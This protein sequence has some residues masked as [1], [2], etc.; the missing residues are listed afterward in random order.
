MICK[1]R[2]ADGSLQDLLK[3]LAQ[4]EENL[5]TARG[6][7]DGSGGDGDSKGV[8]DACQTFEM[9]EAAQRSGGFL[10]AVARSHTGSNV[11]NYLFPMLF[12]RYITRKFRSNYDTLYKEAMEQH[13]ES[14]GADEGALSKNLKGARSIRRVKGNMPPE[15]LQEASTKISEFLR[16]FF[17]NSTE[18]RCALPE[19]IIL[20][21]RTAVLVLVI[22]YCRS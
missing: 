22:T 13:L 5:T 20:L 17:D 14:V 18:H 19:Q 6:L 10:H 3:Q 12:F 8:S 16:S 4:E 9:Y 1:S 15:H 2:F 11:T 7:E 21:I